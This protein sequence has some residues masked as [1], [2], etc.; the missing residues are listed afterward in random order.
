MHSLP[1][2]EWFRQL[3]QKR[4]EKRALQRFTQALVQSVQLN[5]S[6][7]GVVLAPLLKQPLH[8]SNSEALEQWAEQQLIERHLPI[9]NEALSLLS[10]AL[11][12]QLYQEHA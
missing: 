4:E 10:E 1:E 2:S 9:N 3:V 8:L 12:R 5:M 7:S 6:A 11:K